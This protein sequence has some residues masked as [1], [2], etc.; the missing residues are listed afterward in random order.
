MPEKKSFASRKAWLDSW[1]HVTHPQVRVVQTMKQ[2]PRPKIEVEVEAPSSK[3]TSPAPAPA[4]TSGTFGAPVN[5]T[6]SSV[7]RLS[8]TEAGKQMLAQLLADAARGSEPK[9]KI[10]PEDW[11]HKTARTY[12]VPPGE[13]YIG[14]L[15]YV[16]GDELY[17]GIFGNVGDYSDGLYTKKDS[18]DFFFVGST[19]YGDGA[20][21]GSDGR[22]FCVDAGIIGICP[23]SICGKEDADTYYTLTAETECT[24]RGGVFTFTNRN[25]D[26]VI[27]TAGSD[28]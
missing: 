22:E 8:E 18:T 7:P 6:S 24:I 11:S 1:R 13:Y 23:K 16:L 19:A 9:V 4:P 28:E 15:C 3:V 12:T 2:A 21:A 20:Y 14:D 5:A 10:N 25:W 26:L 27:N 17:D